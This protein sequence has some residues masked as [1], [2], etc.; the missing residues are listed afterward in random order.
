MGANIGT[1][2]TNTIVSFG[3]SMDKTMF[4]RAFAG[5][6]GEGLRAKT[7]LRKRVLVKTGTTLVSPSHVCFGR[8]FQCSTLLQFTTALTGYASLYSSHWKLLSIL[9]TNS[10]AL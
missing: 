3:Q 7:D 1:T 10:V 4:R 6:T 2:V 8:Y 5:A 9:C